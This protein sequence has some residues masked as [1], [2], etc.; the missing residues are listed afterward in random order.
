M[1]HPR[2]LV[3]IR[4][5]MLAIPSV[6]IFRREALGTDRFDLLELTQGEV[7]A[8]IKTTS[9][10]FRQESVDVSISESIWFHCI[11]AGS[12]SAESNGL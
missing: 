11:F 6:A 9:R 3:T 12:M 8:R 2:K 10:C 7:A 1:K 5:S 4:L